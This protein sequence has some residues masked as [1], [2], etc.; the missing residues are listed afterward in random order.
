MEA[1]RIER[2]AV[3]GAGTMGHGIA[4]VCALSGLEVGVT[5]VKEEFLQRGLESISGSLDKLRERG[6]ISDLERDQVLER[7]STDVDL[8]N[9]VSPAGLVIEAVPEKMEIKRDVFERI[10]GSAKEEAILA[11][12]TSSL[13]VTD[14][15]SITSRPGRFL[16]LHFFNP[17]VKM[18]L[19]EVIKG[20]KTGEE[21]IEAAMDFTRRLGK[22]PV[23][24]RK[25]APGFIVNAIL[26]PYLLEAVW[27]KEREDLEMK[28]VDAAV[29]EK[30]NFPMG[31][32]ELLDMVGLD[33]AK[34]IGEVIGWPLPESLTE[35]VDRDRLGKKSGRG[36]YNYQQD[37]VDY[38]SEDAEKFDPLPLL[39]LMVNESAGV[40]Q[41][42]VA[43]IDDI[44]LA[45]K[46]GAGLP[47]GPIAL[48]KEKGRGVIKEGLD[49]LSK[50]NPSAEERY[51]PYGPLEEGFSEYEF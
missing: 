42:E 19:V 46:L 32:F 37:G 9:V 7:I 38:S 47:R 1:D 21:I 45:L 26:F 49:Y 35:K 14:L 44:D 40:L 33:V 16:G 29:V 2:V 23:Y 50:I 10:D 13:S 48:G 43:S 5:D 28:A 3:V 8:D 39:A 41:N 12:N 27:L 4:E 11:T 30:L 18:K 31:P 22:E 15:A 24:C 51:E 17:P 25:D 20:E 34:E 36:F 6:R